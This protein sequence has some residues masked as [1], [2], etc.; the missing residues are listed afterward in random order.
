MNAYY[1]HLPKKIVE[2]LR[3]DAGKIEEGRTAVVH[4]A[5]KPFLPEAKET[6]A[7][8]SLSQTLLP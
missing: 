4:I 5:D 1:E 7:G 3:R 2:A 8:R 6:K